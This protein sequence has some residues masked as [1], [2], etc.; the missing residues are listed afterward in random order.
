M[1]RFTQKSVRF[2]DGKL[3][4]FRHFPKIPKA[5]PRREIPEKHNITITKRYANLSTK[6][7]KCQQVANNL[8]TRFTKV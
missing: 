3:A 8:S 2:H 7:T 5:L 6:S 1:L 4:E